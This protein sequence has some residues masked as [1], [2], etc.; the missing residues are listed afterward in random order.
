[1]TRSFTI[2]AG[3]T[4]ILLACG[5]RQIPREQQQGPTAQMGGSSG[6]AL[7]E[8]RAE[9]RD[10][11]GRTLG[12][13]ELRDGGSVILITGTLHGLPPG[14]HALHLHETGRCEPPFGSAGGH[15]N[16]TQRQH[17]L[18]NPNGPH[19]GDLASLEASADSVAQVRT[20]TAGGSLR[21][22]NGLLDG[23]GAAV[24]VHARPDDGKTDPSGNSGARIACG[25]VVE[26]G[27]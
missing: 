14:S 24:V 11:A 2:L 17:G 23:D 27:S 18:Q 16:P 1:M 21:G 13:L 10:A 22:Q 8:G 20:S 26:T 4:S 15:W 5:G 25:V 19:L 6:D 12:T 3:A 9:L 7:N